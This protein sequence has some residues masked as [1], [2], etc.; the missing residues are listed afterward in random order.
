VDL[1]V[2][3]GDD[4]GDVGP[5]RLAPVTAAL[6]AVVAA[7]WLSGTCLMVGGWRHIRSRF[8]THSRPATATPLADEVETWLHHQQR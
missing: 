7:D 3:V 5:D 2:P 4:G 8:G 1:D 6:F